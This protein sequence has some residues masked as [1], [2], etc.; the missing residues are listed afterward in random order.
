[1]L[2]GAERM[3]SS[4]TPSNSGF[5]ET[6]FGPVIF[7]YHSGQRPLNVN[8]FIASNCAGAASYFVV[9]AF[10]RNV[11]IVLPFLSDSLLFALLFLAIFQRWPQVNVATF[12][13]CPLF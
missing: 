1:M 3:D 8:T 6:Y 5:L 9:L 13:I 11:T 4:S 2:T 10:V 7:E 12:G